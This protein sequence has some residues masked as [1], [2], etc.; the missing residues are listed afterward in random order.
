M[1]VTAGMTLLLHHLDE[2]LE[3]LGITYTDEEQ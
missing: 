2:A 1:A 3:R